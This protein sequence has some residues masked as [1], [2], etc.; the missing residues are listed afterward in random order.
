MVAGKD[1]VR[2]V[3]PDRDV[4]RLT[5]TDL[6]R[7]GHRDARERHATRHRDRAVVLLRGVE[8]VRL[9]VV[10]DHVVVLRRR[11]VVL[12]R[13]R[14]PAIFGDCR[15]AVIAFDHAIG[16][17]R[18]NPQIVTVAMRRIQCLERLPAIR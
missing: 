11:L 1:D 5:A 6:P 10:R 12:R 3:G 14:L 8:P 18:I 4:A 13:P 17:L 7:V 2:I 15:A 9:P 16:V